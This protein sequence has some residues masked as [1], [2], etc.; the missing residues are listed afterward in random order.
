MESAFSVVSQCPSVI[1]GFNIFQVIQTID[2]FVS[3]SISKK[4]ASSEMK[5][6]EDS[7]SYIYTTIGID[8]EG[9][10]LKEVFDKLDKPHSFSPKK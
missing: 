5:Q 10:Y 4:A 1:E 7:D 6:E 3:D 9:L 2:K 8:P